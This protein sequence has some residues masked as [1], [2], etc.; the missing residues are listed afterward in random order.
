MDSSLLAKHHELPISSFITRRVNSSTFLIIEDD[1]Y[2]EQPYIYV[3]IYPG[4]LLIT[5]TGCNAPR[6]E[7][8]TLTSLRG[9][10]E[11]YPIPLNNHQCLNPRGQKKYIIICS[12]CHYDHIL[13]I[14]QF[15][16]KNPT[17]IASDFDKSF[18]LE[19]FPTHSLCKFNDVQTPQYTISKW[20]R[21]MEFLSLADLPL[22]VQF[23]H[24]PGHTPDSLAW[25]DIDENH[26]YVGD[27]FYERNR[28][29][30]IPELPRHAGQGSEPGAIIFPEEGGN[31]IQFMSSLELLL[32]FVLYQNRE[33]RHKHGLSHGSLLRVLVGC[34]HLTHN[35]DAESMIKEVQALFEDI[36]T[37]NLPVTKSW[38]KRGVEHGFWLKN[39]CARYS[40]SFICLNNDLI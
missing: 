21:H 39:Q 6:S 18:L 24:I 30:P 2:G 34:G 5:D 29:T 13:G 22:R 4:H 9:Y 28:S 17:I 14:P 25:Y 23:L 31:W 11:T 15:L 40:M 7:T 33:L 37:G 1:K 36:I 38:N 10:L 20:A 16:P 32:S 26:L 3:K 35:G 19:D 8:P 27:T 12:H